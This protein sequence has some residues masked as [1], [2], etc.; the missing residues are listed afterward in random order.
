MKKTRNE[1]MV[2]L[3]VIAGFVMLALVVFF[4]S[5]VSLFRSGYSVN[6]LY[7]YVDIMD[8][9][10]PVRMAGVRIGEVSKVELVHDENKGGTLVRVK[11]FIDGHVKIRENY[12][13]EIRGTHILSEPHIEITPVEGDAPLIHEGATIQ[14]K[15]LEPIENLI[16]KAQDVANG[17]DEVVNGKL[18][19]SEGDMKQAVLSLKKSTDQLNG[20]LTNISQGQGTAGKL[21]SSDELYQ[22]V[23][24]LVAE[25]KAHPWRLLKRDKGPESN[26][27]R[28]KFLGIF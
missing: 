21:V 8:R 14:G 27:P 24:G 16:K 2:G 18:D 6:V 26:Q 4:V 15:K 11:L 12:V 17:L 3:F 9:G 13:F 28:K 20:I 19:N 5:G 1:M 10:A 7:D 23:R 22:D 25:I